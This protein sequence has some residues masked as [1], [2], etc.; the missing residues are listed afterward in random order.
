[1]LE[2]PDD[3]DTHRPM[4]QINLTPMLGVLVALV[5]IFALSVPRVDKLAVDLHGVDGPV[6]WFDLPPPPVDVS[7]DRD[8]ALDWDGRGVSSAEFEQR[9]AA[10]DPQRPPYFVLHVQGQV[11]Y[12]TFAHVLEA[13]QQRGVRGFSFEQ[14]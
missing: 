8:G 12:A 9:L 14:E 1:M 11:K 6:D 7:V 3:N 2:F 5:A 10:I 4:A 13:L